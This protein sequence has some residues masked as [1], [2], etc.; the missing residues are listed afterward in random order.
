MEDEGHLPSSLYRFLNVFSCHSILSVVVVVDVVRVTAVFLSSRERRHCKL[1]AA[2]GGGVLLLHPDGP[3][4]LL[5][6][7]SQAESGG[8]LLP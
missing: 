7:P 3:S 6:K 5:Q 8:K 4:S 1:P 2:E